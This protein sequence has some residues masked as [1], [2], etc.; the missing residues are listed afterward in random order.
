MIPVIKASGEDIPCGVCKQQA[1]PQD[2][3]L[4]GADESQQGGQDGGAAWGSHQR[5][6]QPRQVRLPH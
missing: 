3:V 1:S 4:G 6:G 5:K 2:W